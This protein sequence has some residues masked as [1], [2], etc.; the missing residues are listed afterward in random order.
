MLA[1]AGDGARRAALE[2]RVE[3]LG[4]GSQVHFL[5]SVD[6]LGPVLLAA[7]VVVL[8]SREEAQP[9]SI[10]EAMARARPV[11]AS[12]VGGLRD[13]IDD[14][15]NGLLVRP[16]DP[17]ALAQALILLHQRPDFARR[18]GDEAGDRVRA[19]STWAHAVARHEV[20][21][22][23]VLGFAGFTPEVEARGRAASSAGSRA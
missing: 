14:G 20:V 18:L 15:E 19:G 6:A 13:L 16:A 10:L 3:E 23:E 2:R 9:L 22:D 7:N 4:L 1:L 17:E 21:Y 12:A 11:V 5:G 8:A